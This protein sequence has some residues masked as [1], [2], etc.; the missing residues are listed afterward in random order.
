MFGTYTVKAL[1]SPDPIHL[2]VIV[3]RGLWSKDALIASLFLESFKTCHAYV[4]V[5]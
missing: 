3:S 1:A 4:I 2:S 5:Y